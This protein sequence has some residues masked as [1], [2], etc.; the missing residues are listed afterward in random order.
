MFDLFGRKAKAENAAL[1]EALRIEREEIAHLDQIHRELADIIRE[2]DQAIYNISQ[3][4]PD[5]N[6]MRP[7]FNQMQVGQ[8]S[9]M[10]NES[11]RI[12][13]ILKTELLEVYRK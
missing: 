1:R 7:I 12:T 10:R 6:R 13:N 9:R 5:W 11:N 3:C 2:N 8:E 4:A